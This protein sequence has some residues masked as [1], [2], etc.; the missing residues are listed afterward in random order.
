M[1]RRHVCNAMH[2]SPSLTHTRTH[3]GAVQG[4]MAKLHALS[5]QEYV[6]FENECKQLAKVGQDTGTHRTRHNYQTA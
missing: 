6:A 5:E 1:T 3:M 4:E 2:A